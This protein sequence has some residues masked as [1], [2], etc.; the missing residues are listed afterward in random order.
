MNAVI[1]VSALMLLLTLPAAADQ[2][3]I[4][5]ELLDQMVGNW[6]MTGEIGGSSVTHDVAAE[7]VLGHQYVRFHELAREVGNGGAPAYEAVVFIGWNETLGRYTCL[8]LDD[9]AS[10]AQFPEHTGYAEPAV[11]ELAFVF[12]TGEDS[13]IHTTFSYNREADIWHW[14]I[15]IQRDDKTSTFARVSLARQ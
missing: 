6:V 10:G 2:R 7:W 9:T 1:R 14:V 8:W 5:D 15:V 3:G 12:A 4:Q 13:A 11:D